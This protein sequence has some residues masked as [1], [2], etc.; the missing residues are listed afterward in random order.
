MQNPDGPDASVAQRV[1]LTWRALRDGTLQVA[2]HLR[3]IADEIA[4]AP[5]LMSGLVNVSS[6]SAPALMFARTAG[7]AVR[8]G[9][10]GPLPSTSSQ[11]PAE[12]QSELF[13][14]FARLF[15][16]LTGRAVHL[17][18][19]DEDIRELM[20]WRVR[21]NTQAFER[22]VKEAEAALGDFYNRNAIALFQHAKAFGGMRLLSGGQ[23]RFERS[24]LTAVRLTSLYADTQLIPDPIYPFLAT[25]L[26]LNAAPL[27]M[28]I[29]LFYAL[30]LRPLVDAALP[31]PP[32]FVFPSFE[33]DLEERDAYTK[34][35]LERLVLSVIAPYCDTTISSLDELFDY[36]KRQDDGF[37][38]SLLNAGLF[39]PPG[40]TPGKIL[41]VEQA[42]EDYFSRITGDR[43]SSVV[44]LLR[45]QP[46]NVLLVNG[47]FERLGPQYHLLENANEMNAQ[48]LLSQDTH[49]HYFEISANASAQELVRT[50]VLSE[51][52][53][54]TLRAIQD[55]SMSWLA[56]IPMDTIRDLIANGEH[57]WF[58]EELNKY[59]TQISNTS[60]GDPNAMVRE[61]SHGLASIVQRQQTVMS[62]IERKY[63]PGN[64][65]MIAAGV[66]GA[67][68]AATVTM[69]PIL[70]PLLGSAVP[71]AAAVAAAGGAAAGVARE[72]VAEW[73]EKRQVRRSMIG[74][75]A[76]RWRRH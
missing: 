50:S 56:E 19:K 76:T 5:L 57:L 60:P 21:H 25:D 35:G 38:Q 20:M 48:P 31:V 45:Q 13:G 70:S 22:E 42:L 73:V 1:F 40:G 36:A 69:L 32:V 4:A 15:G 39:V 47:I 64:V 9:V 66:A 33:H 51:Q 41:T 16:A 72:K 2:P 27:Q 26:R 23:R 37:A 53:F 71:T 63:T 55:E 14:L 34:I 67:G 74:V 61:V 52:S 62:E 18:V 6:L 46:P 3:E 12:L 59:T 17:V 54:D 68:M 75:L 49:W 11:S 8:Q 28:A 43:E 65:A 10:P 24:A 58:R 30:K 7:M 29:A 44:A